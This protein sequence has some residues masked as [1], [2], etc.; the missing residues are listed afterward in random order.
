[1]LIPSPLEAKLYYTGLRSCPVLVARTGATRW[2]PPTGIEGG[3]KL[4]ELRTVSRN[5]PIRE[6]WEG[7]LPQKIIAFLDSMDVKWTSLDIV[8]IGNVEEYYIPL[9]HIAPTILWIG[10]IPGSLSASDGVVAAFKCRK[11][12]E[13]NDITDVEVEIRESVVTR[14]PDY[15][16]LDP[17]TPPGGKK[18]GGK[19]KGR[20]R[21]Q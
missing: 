20:K 21:R 10:V 8:R 19:K 11:I 2:E 13:E 3:Q 6:A 1:M 18:K 5:H 17:S 4:K 14:W 12:L 9:I 15:S 16:Q 7:D